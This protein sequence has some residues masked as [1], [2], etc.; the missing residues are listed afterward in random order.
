[1]RR[2]KG[3][4]KMDDVVVPVEWIVIISWR[5]STFLASYVFF[6]VRVYTRAR[7][8]ALAGACCSPLAEPWHGISAAAARPS[9]VGRRCRADL[10]SRSKIVQILR[11]PADPNERECENLHYRLLYLLQFPWPFLLVLLP[12][13]IVVNV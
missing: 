9:L 8:H 12:L 3:R 4:D 10:H 6:V 13:F 5:G 1:M 11:A 2:G 7:V